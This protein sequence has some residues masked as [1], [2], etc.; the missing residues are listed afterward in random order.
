MALLALASWPARTQQALPSRFTVEI[1]VFRTGAGSMAEDLS[2]ATANIGATSVG[3]T[4]TAE[5]Q[6]RLSDS[7][8]RLRATAGYR[9]IAHT[10]WSQAPSAWNSRIGVSAEELGLASAGITGTIVLERG[11]YLHLGFDL[12][13]ADGGSRYT[14]AEVRRVRPNERHYFDHP[15]VGII[16]LV[17][18]PG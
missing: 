8:S 18:G 7:A 16:A 11:Q 15:A 13:I 2:A 4:A 9:V 10:A 12:H 14:L 6:R 3:V 17:T 1:V 5:S